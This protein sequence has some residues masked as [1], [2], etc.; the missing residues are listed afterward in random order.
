MYYG[1]LEDRES[2]LVKIAFQRFSILTLSGSVCLGGERGE[3][4]F[5]LGGGRGVAIDDLG[6]SM[7]KVS[8][9]P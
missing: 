8:L 1:E 6:S 9:R 4:V 5:F 7:S 2:K 3:E